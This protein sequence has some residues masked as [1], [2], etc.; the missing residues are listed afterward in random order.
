MTLF[1]IHEIFRPVIKQDD[2]IR[3]QIDQQSI[4]KNGTEIWGID[5]YRDSISFIPHEG[6]EFIKTPDECRETKIRI[7]PIT[8]YNFIRMAFDIENNKYISI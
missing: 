2:H 7:S 6:N 4:I 5:L 8:M 3:F 1:D